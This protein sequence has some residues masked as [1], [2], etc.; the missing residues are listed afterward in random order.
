[1]PIKK[2]SG[3]NNDFFLKYIKKAV[4]FLTYQNGN[5]KTFRKKSGTVEYEQ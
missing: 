3:G 5:R 2:N 4:Y 1:M